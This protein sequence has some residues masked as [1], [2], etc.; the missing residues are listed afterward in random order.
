M[1]GAVYDESGKGI[2][3]VKIF[4]LSKGSTPF[5][6]GITGSFAIPVSVTLD[7]IILQ[8][9]GY[10]T[11]KQLADVSRFQVF[12][13]KPSS[14]SATAIKQKPK[15]ISLIPRNK[16]ESSTNYF[17]TGETYSSL[18]EHDFTSAEKFPQTGFAL[19]IDRASYSN[20]RRFLNSDM[21]VLPDAV[22]IEEMLNYFELDHNKNNTKNFLC[23]SQITEAPWNT[24]NELLFINIKAPSIN[25]DDI[26]PANLVF[27][28]DISGSMD[29]PNRLPLLKSAFK[30]LV[31]NL[32]KQDTVAIVVYGG[33][34]GTY[35]QPTSCMYKDSI[36]NRIEKLEAGGET[37][38]EAAIRTAYRLAEKMYN[39][40]A[41]NRIILATDGD[42]NVGQ[43]SDEELE[44]IVLTHR[45]SGIYLTCL[46]VGMGNYKDSKLEALANKGNGNFAYLDNVN[47][48]EKVLVKEFTKT[49]YAVA[50]DAYAEINFNPQFVKR[51][52]LI[53]FDNKADAEAD[54]TSELE[55]GEVGTGHSSTAVFEIEP[56]QV[57]DSNSINKVAQL[58]L[59]YKPQG[60]DTNVTLQFTIENNFASFQN[61]D[62]AI[63]FATAVIMFGG[64][65]KQ[66]PLW[67]NYSWD[68]VI[69]I[70]K[71]SAD[72]NDY[73]QAEFLSLVEKAKNIYSSTKKKKRGKDE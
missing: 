71:A 70:A 19:N 6:T 28:I 5:F 63:R 72:M 66:S 67:K 24:K 17:N 7:T 56:E 65:L 20:I 69:Q 35:L 54:S 53:G 55:G 57:H 51:Y 60:K 32:R 27:L 43:T 34:V 29:Q 1:R 3:N 26:P 15:L 58:M 12:N 8:A 46:G 49:L 38:G 23:K 73:A 44:D 37:P 36:K 47:E 42:F 33:W 14:A 10:E 61:A 45:Q 40:N 25:V 62:S 52:R 16:N 68:D 39:K 22:R 4:L 11:I 21:Q 30:M 64:L 18:V 13:M 31:N 59:H 41:N 9:S 50:D 2:S 48:A